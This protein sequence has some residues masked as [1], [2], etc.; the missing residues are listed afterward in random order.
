VLTTKSNQS[1]NYTF[2]PVKIGNYSVST[3]VNGFQTLTREN[4]H[5]N[6]QQRMEVDLV[7]LLARSLKTVT[8]STEAPL[9]QTETSGV[10]QTIDTQTIN[11]T[12]LNGRNWVYIAQ[13]TAGSV[14]ASANSGGTRGSGPATSL[15]T[16][17]APSKT[18]S[19]WTAWTTT[20]TWSTSSMAPAS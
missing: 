17:S 9:L 16:D 18:I 14:S 10:G 11:N 13:L 8:V 12:P 2:S 20:Q 1:G 3:S 15:R 6:A 7:S 19:S 5:V 4:L